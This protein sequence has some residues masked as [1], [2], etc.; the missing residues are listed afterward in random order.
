MIDTKD[1]TQEIKKAQDSTLGA[2]K[3]LPKLHLIGDEPHE[4]SPE[5][6]QEFLDTVFHV[7]PADGAH[8]LVY[9][10]PNNNPGMPA[11]GGVDA[12][13]NKVMRRTTKARAVLCVSRT[14]TG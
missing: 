8:R 13:V 4:Y 11:P 6:A 12:L 14:G 7:K 1:S 5:Q 3:V 9:T 2:L 10:S